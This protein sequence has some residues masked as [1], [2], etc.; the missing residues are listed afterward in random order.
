MHGPQWVQT[1]RLMLWEAF[2]GHLASEY[3]QNRSEVEW[4]LGKPYNVFISLNLSWNFSMIMYG[5]GPILQH[6]IICSGSRVCCKQAS[7]THWPNTIIL[8]EFLYVY[9]PGH[10][11]TIPN[12][13]V[14]KPVCNIMWEALPLT[15]L[16]L[17]RPSP[18]RAAS[19]YRPTKPGG[20]MQHKIWLIYV[21]WACYSTWFKPPISWQLLCIAV[22]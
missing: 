21:S 7:K 18:Y 9:T 16:V 22:T 8:Q 6:R 12:K 13:T 3:N 10:E 14:L 19:N 4:N 2:Q 1:Y 11:H 5:D 17:P 20:S 15:A